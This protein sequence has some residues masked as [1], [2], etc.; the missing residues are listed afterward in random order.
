MGAPAEQWYYAGRD[1][2]FFALESH[3]HYGRPSAFGLPHLP[4]VARERLSGDRELALEPVQLLPNE[5][6]A[7]S[8][9]QPRQR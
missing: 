6:V 5:L 9:R 2:L 4:P 8:S 7:K 1:H 3:I